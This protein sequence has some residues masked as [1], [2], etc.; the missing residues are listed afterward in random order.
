MDLEKTTIEYEKYRHGYP[1]ELLNRLKDYEIGLKEQRIL[2]IGT[3]NGIFARDLARNGSEVIGIDLSS[4]L[5][6]QAERINFEDKLPIKYLV[7]NVENL[8]FESNSIEVVTAAYC[9]HWFNKLKAAEEIIRVLKPNGRLAIINYDWLPQTNIS[10]YTNELIQKFN[11][12][13]TSKDK[14]A[15]YPEWIEELH[16]TG[17]TSIET[18]SF[19][20]NVNYTTESWI[21]RIQASP[22]I[23]GALSKEEMGCFNQKLES[24][25]EHEVIEESFDIPYRIFAIIGRKG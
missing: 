8:P 10:C 24:F 9:W 21:G 23:G 16:S 7:G 15:M 4:K 22:E 1:K 18:F 19:D 13:S 14:L 11:R 20:V 6:E 3:S 12:K 5:I 2:D 25:L 17:F